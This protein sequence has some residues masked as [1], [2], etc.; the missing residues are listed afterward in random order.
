M[1]IQ[2]S[3][4]QIIYFNEENN[5]TVVDLDCSG[6]LITAVGIFPDIK[7]GELLEIEGDKVYNPRFG[8]QIKVTDVRFV[9]PSKKEDIIQFLSSGLIKGIGKNKAKD[10]VNE[11]GEDTLDIIE[12][13]P[14]RLLKIKGIGKVT[15]REI[16][17]HI[18]MF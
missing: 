17:A 10:I 6:E 3:V 7:E 13:D 15:A 1:T 5:Y 12:L 8:E 4:Y 9:K 14:T 18:I 16:S 2:G 11:F